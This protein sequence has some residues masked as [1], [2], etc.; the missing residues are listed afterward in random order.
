M[1]TYSLDELKGSRLMYDKNPP[2]FLTYLVFITLILIVGLITLA[3][4]TSKTEVVKTQG[5]LL[6]TNKTPIQSQTS[7]KITNVYKKNGDY[8]VTGDVLFELDSSQTTIQIIAL[9]SKLTSVKSFVNE[10]EE[11]MSAIKDIDLKNL[12]NINPFKDSLNYYN[13]QVVLESINNINNSIYSE[14]ECISQRTSIIN[15]YLIEFYQSYNQYKYEMEGIYSEIDAY[16][17]LLESYKI[18]ASCDGYIN[19][20]LDIKTGVIVDN[21]SIGSISDKLTIENSIFEC[22]VAAQ[23]RNFIHEGLSAEVIVQGLS[24]SKYGTINGKILEIGSDIIT[25]K[26]NNAYYKVLIQPDSILL[27]KN[28]NKIEL[29]NGQIGEI[30][31]KYEDLTWLKWAFKKIGITDR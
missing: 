31:I 30:R 9:E 11:L 2:K 16:K 10:F 26:D 1:K 20:T 17:R 19:Y 4:F 18:C 6:S 8:V 29:M 21:S 23:N 27:N 13:Y 5:I 12:N 28:D 25:D 22:Y 14:E 3:S 24:Q 7:G 15:Q